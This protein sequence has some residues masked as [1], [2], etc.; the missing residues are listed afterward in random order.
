VGEE[1]LMSQREAQRLAVLGEVVAGRM[2][3]GQAA[4]SL[5]AWTSC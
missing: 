2:K 5:G 1:K 3:V 4:A